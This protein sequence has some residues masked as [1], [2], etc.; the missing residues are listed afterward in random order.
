MK[1]TLDVFA[2]VQFEQSDKPIKA[3]L[4]VNDKEIPVSGKKGKWFTNIPMNNGDVFSLKGNSNEVKLIFCKG[5]IYH[6]EQ[7]AF[8][9]KYNIEKTG[10][11]DDSIYYSLSGERV[12]PRKILITFP[13]TSNFDNI[14][15]RLSA[16]TSLQ[17]RLKDI[18]IIA[19]QDKESVY[20]NYMYKTFGGKYIKPLA[21][22]VIKSLLEKYDLNSTDLIFYGNS[23]GGSIA[24]DYIDEFPSSL[25]FI[26]IPQLDLYNYDA[27]NA[28]MRFSLSDD[29][30]NYYRF[31]AYLPSIKNKNVTYSLAENDFDSSRGLPLK[32]FSGINSVMLK[33]MEHAGSAMELVKRQFTKVIQQVTDDGL[34]V[35]DAI[36]VRFSYAN[37]KLYATRVLGS[38]K[39]ESKMQLVYAEIE[40]F[41][42]TSSYSVSLNKRF[43][44]LLVVFWKNGFDVLQHLPEGEFDIRLHVYYRFREFV[45]P[46]RSRIVLD[47]NNVTIL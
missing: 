41:N 20:G 30:L 18:L 11:D 28:L 39:E 36:D 4:V 37:N 27:L 25:F 35:R 47:N 10:V 2:N 9:E 17:S 40:F 23:K 33:D 42:D 5:K 32:Q 43:D 22:D 7:I 24:I 14:N 46:V 15:Y 21:V 44:K 26:D 16:M 8:D 38:F 13:G 12:S 29:V 31:L 45:Y 19:F 3:I 34:V 6:P 1:E